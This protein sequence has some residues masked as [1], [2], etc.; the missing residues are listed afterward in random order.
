MQ[1]SERHFHVRI[2]HH[3]SSLIVLH[4]QCFPFK[5]QGAP[6]K[7]SI[8]V[9]EELIRHTGVNH[10]AVG[11]NL[12]LDAL[13][14]AVQLHRDE[15]IVQHAFEDAEVAVFRHSLPCIIEI[16]GIIGCAE[17]KA[18]DDG[19]GQLPWVMFPLFVGIALDER[20]I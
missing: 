16:V 20:L 1:T 3:C 15:R 19:R 9:L 2:V 8:F 6:F 17:R 7:L 18:A 4:R 10:R 5:A 12:R 11:G 13:V 14:L